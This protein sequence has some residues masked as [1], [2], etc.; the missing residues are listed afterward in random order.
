MTSEKPWES[1]TPDEKLQARFNAWNAAEG[2]NF[3]SGQAEE[4]YKAR[5]KRFT[6]AMLLKTPDRVPLNPTFGGFIT[7]Y[8]G[9]TE[10]EV[11]YDPDKAADATLRGTQEFVTDGKVAVGGAPGKVFD[12]LDYKLFD[13]P[14]HGVKENEGWQFKEAEYMTADEYD[15]FIRDP[16]DYWLRVHMPRILGVAKG[17]VQLQPPV[18]MI[19]QVHVV[20]NISR[21]GLPEVHVC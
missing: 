21:F 9:Y 16:S 15:D 7:G 12:I 6:D 14:G 13:W 19:E 17:L 1:L 4:D 3:A 10:Q 11:M 8:Y 2:I 18:Y 20:A 5:T